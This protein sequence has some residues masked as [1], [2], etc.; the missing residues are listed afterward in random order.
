MTLNRFPRLFRTSFQHR[1]FAYNTSNRLEATRSSKRLYGFVAVSIGVVA[2]AYS[3]NSSL[4]F[5]EAPKSNTISSKS[6]TPS[7]KI[8]TVEEVFRHKTPESGIWVIYGDGV[9]DIT[10][11][12]TMHPGGKEKISLAAGGF[13]EPFWEVFTIHH[14]QAVY[15]ILESLR[16]GDVD[17][18]SLEV[19]M[20]AQEKK[21]VE[22]MADP[23]ANEPARWEGLIPRSERPCN[24]E[25]PPDALLA[26]GHITNNTVFYVRNH[27]PVPDIKSDQHRLTLNIPTASGMK[28]VVL[29]IDD[30]KKYKRHDVSATLQCAGNRR[31][32]MSA[33]K[34]TQGLQ[35]AQGAIGNAIWSGVFLSDVLKAHGL[36]ESLTREYPHVQFMGAEGYGASI[37][38]EKALNG[39]VLIAFEMNHE[40][41]PRDHGYPLRV[42]VPGTVAARSVKWVQ[43][44]T[45][46]KE[47][48]I[49]HWQRKDYKVVPPWTT[50]DTLP[51]EMSKV[52]LLY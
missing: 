7:Q 8:F 35:W 47:E 31:S 52:C 13:L 28:D 32:D 6:D 37:P 19:Y 29:T 51:E 9:Y 18:K 39:D 10:S 12:I 44:I 25:T 17:L 2:T 38:I 5:G 15:D 46:A 30:L 41:L 40:P 27:F 20:E 45:I 26:S 49:S 16:I 33:A 4:I 42:I 34:P 1:R 24:A 23:F 48:S 11:F 21:K 22:Q 36:S 43:E 3:L 14:K 50:P